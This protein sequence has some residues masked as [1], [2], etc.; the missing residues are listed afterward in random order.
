[1]NPNSI[2]KFLSKWKDLPCGDEDCLSQDV[3]EEMSKGVKKPEWTQHLQSC[4]TCTEI[5]HILGDES[6]NHLSVMD[7]FASEKK[8]AADTVSSNRSKSVFGYLRTLFWL[9][10]PKWSVGTMAT[11]VMILGLFGYFSYREVKLK[12]QPAEIAYLQRDDYA[13]ALAD[14]Q[15]AI[16]SLPSSISSS[17][18]KREQADE[19]NANILQANEST[20]KVNSLYNEHTIQNDQR[21]QFSALLVNYHSKL[22]PLREN[23]MASQGSQTKPITELSQTPDTKS[24]AEVLS[25]VGRVMK[26]KDI[27]PGSEPSEL[28]K[29]EA[30]RLAFEEVEVLSVEND[31][32]STKLI[33]LT[34]LPSASAE[35]TGPE[36]T[37]LENTVNSIMGKQ[38][39]NVKILLKPNRPIPTSAFT[40]PNN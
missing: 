11:L 12:Q 18:N 39:I 19:L 14:L 36:T 32:T 40:R 7:R 34:Y 38:K 4:R 29:V 27:D 26:K 22:T 30:I 9:N 6:L 20:K 2:D 35:K 28:Q 25:A 17:R 10:Q 24:I 5:L 16:D 3:L 21:G 13:Y 37:D 15:H 33:T 23:L 8:I 31:S 1:M